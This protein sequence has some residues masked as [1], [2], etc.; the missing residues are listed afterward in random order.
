[1]TEIPAPA[2]TLNEA[3]GVCLAVCQRALLEVRALSRIPGPAG[4]TGPAGTD[5]KNGERRAKGE[6]GRN[7]SDLTYQQEY[8][9]EQVERILKTGKLTTDDGGRTL[10]WA[11]GDVVQEIKTAIILDAGIWKDGI[12]YVAG[13]AVTLAGSLFIAKVA[14]TAQPGMSDD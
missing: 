6:P 13:D 8:I 2:Y 12:S 3:I 14:T 10:R 7:A 9:G 5:G 11:L 1:M 4:A